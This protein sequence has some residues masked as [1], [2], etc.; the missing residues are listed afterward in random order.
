[1]KSSVYLMINNTCTWH[2][3]IHVGIDKFWL[4]M[5]NFLTFKHGSNVSGSSWYGYNHGCKFSGN[6]LISGFL[7]RKICDFR[8]LMLV[9]LYKKCK[10]TGFSLIFRL[11]ATCIHGLSHPWIKADLCLVCATDRCTIYTI[12]REVAVGFAEKPYGSRFALAGSHWTES[13][14]KTS[15]C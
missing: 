6:Y 5:L 12:A 11:F 10:E 9:C 7:V 3:V 14:T 8:L 1:M 4:S 13:L 15:L 2:K